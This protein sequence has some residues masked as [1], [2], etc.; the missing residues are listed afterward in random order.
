MTEQFLNSSQIRSFL[1]HVSSEGMS[2]GVGMNIRRKALGYG[3]ALDDAAHAAGGESS[4][5]PVNEKSRD[6]LTRRRQS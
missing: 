5:A 4:A 3:D 2:Q 1:Q 6:V